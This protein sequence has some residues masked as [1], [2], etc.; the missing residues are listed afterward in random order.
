MRSVIE[1]AGH[2][3]IMFEDGA[4]LYAAYLE[5]PTSLVVTDW[6]M[7]RMTGVDVCERIRAT[8]RLPYT[9]VIIVTTLSSAEHTLNA[10]HAGVDDLIAKPFEPH[11]LGARL[12]AVE[13]AMN[14]REEVA[15]RAAL[16]EC[17]KSVSYDHAALYSLL[18]SLAAN[19]RRQRAFARCRSFLRRQLAAAHNGG[20]PRRESDRLRDELRE[21]ERIEDEAE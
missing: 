11:V 15:L 3:A 1:K 19:A 20:A 10:F 7:P 21:L 12:H 4:D 18:G 5:R 14:R 2:E 17:Q 6:L 13:R 16:E 9:H 8:P